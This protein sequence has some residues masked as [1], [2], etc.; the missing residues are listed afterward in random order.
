M[1]IWRKTYEALL[2]RLAGSRLRGSRNKDCS[3]GGGVAGSR[4]GVVAPGVQVLAVF[5]P[6]AERRSN[7]DGDERSEA[8]RSLVVAKP[9]LTTHLTPNTYPVPT[10]I[11]TP[12][13]A[14][15]ARRVETAEVP[16]HASRSEHR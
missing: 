6:H 7:D 3:L 13:P 12:A 11:A 15:A 14:R 9:P 1:G 8:T 5:A 4:F 10:E 2:Q 16:I